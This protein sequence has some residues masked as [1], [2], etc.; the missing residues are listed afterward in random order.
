MKTIHT[1]QT[2]TCSM[3]SP[4]WQAEYRLSTSDN[5]GFIGRTGFV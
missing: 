4:A 5:K 3:L 2:R 1:P